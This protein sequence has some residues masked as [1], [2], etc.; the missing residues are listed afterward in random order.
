MPLCYFHSEQLRPLFSVLHGE[1]ERERKNLPPL[2]NQVIVVGNL[3]TEAWVTKC[4]LASDGILM[5]VSFPFLESAITGFS[6]WLR[7][8]LTPP[9]SGSYFLPPT[10]ERPKPLGLAELEV[11]LLGMLTE[12]HNDELLRDLGMSSGQLT[13]SQ[14]VALA[15]S[16]AQELRETILH[17][18]ALLSAISQG[19]RQAKSAGEKLWL[20][21]YQA[22]ESTQRPFPAWEPALAEKIAQH[23][24]SAG[25]A[26]EILHLFGIPLLSEYHLRIL[27]AMAR[28][29][30]VKVYMT[31][32]SDYA[33][34]NNNLLRTAG[35]KAEQFVSLLR[36]LCEHY[37]TT[38]TTTHVP[39]EAMTGRTC[40][41]YALPGYWR[42]AELLADEMH[43]ILLREPTL[44]QSDIGV[45]LTQPELHYAAFE[46]A[47]AMR[48]LIAFSRERFYEVPHALAELWQIIADAVEHGISR[49]LL[50]RYALH[51]MIAQHR[52]AEPAMVEQWLTALEKAH[53]FRDDYP[54]AQEVFSIQAALQRIQRGVILHNKA[55]AVL[56]ASYSLR[57]LD[58]LDFAVGFHKFL[59]P[60][61]SAKA[62]L[63]KLTGKKLAEAM[64]LLQQEMCGA[65]ESMEELASWFDRVQ[66]LPGFDRLNLPQV[67][68]LLAHHLPGKSLAQQTSREGVTFSSLAATCYTKHTQVLFDLCEDADRK[69]NQ[70]DYLFPELMTAPTRFTGIEQL[71]YQLAL[72]LSSDTRNVIF[73]YSAQDPATGADKYPSQLLASV[74]DAAEE[75]GRTH[76]TRSNF[77]TTLLQHDQASCAPIA[78]D[79]DRRTAWLLRNK[80]PHHPPLS[81]YT[82]PERSLLVSVATLEIRDLLAYLRNPARLLLRRHLPPELAIAEFG[83]DEPRLAVGTGARLRFCEE[84]LE[85]ILFDASGSITQTAGDFI[86]FGQALG[87]YAPEG[88]EQA[89]RLLAENDNDERLTRLAHNMR[90]E[91]KLVEYIFRAGISTPFVVEETA[92]LTRLYHPAIRVGATLVTGSSGLLLQ[93][94]DNRLFRLVSAI[95]AERNANLIEL[96]LLLCLFALAGI[97]IKGRVIGLADF[98][99]NTRSRDPIGALGLT[100]RAQLVLPE[101]ACAS[102]YVERLIEAIHAQTIV[103]YDHSLISDPKLADWA[104][105]SAEEVLEKFSSQTEK[106]TGHEVERLQKYFALEADSGSVSFFDTFIRPVALL[107]RQENPARAKATVQNQSAPKTTKHKA[108]R[109]G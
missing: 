94:S 45:S 35:K 51:P 33:A 67:V 104:D 4:F 93:D 8:G 23:Q 32:L 97:R 99:T 36:L 53:G 95:Y 1:I 18:P 72:A 86:R 31:D 96:Y 7:T 43:E 81:A 25:A 98:A 48:E 92:R 102:A 100:L 5:G 83:Y 29:F 57:P 105:L 34:S 49:P 42:A 58:S 30:T 11:L 88:F 71:S 63:A 68:R 62:R 69:Q 85:Q 52:A 12:Q 108:G 89:S 77:P 26:D 27:V 40:A 16:L 41:V 64:L 82:L 13:A 56:P 39:A 22:L 19:K 109:D 10:D 50:V 66:A 21:L 20:R 47:L 46:R 59:R 79:A 37:G 9:K 6:E 65:D 90:A 74:R 78:S 44:C 106:N 14:L 54:K 76:T 103:W 107:D 61:L 87:H 60:L 2:K 17:C 3:E 15:S 101:P 84:Y 80:K 38:L 73:A 24:F 70:A 55:S 75:L 91:L 28:Q